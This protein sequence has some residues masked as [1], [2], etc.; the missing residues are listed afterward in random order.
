MVSSVSCFDI[1]YCS[2]L[3]MISQ[4]LKLLS[5]DFEQRYDPSKNSRYIWFVYKEKSLK[6]YPYLIEFLLDIRSQAAYIYCEDNRKDVAYKCRVISLINPLVAIA[7]SV[8]SL[9]KYFFYTIN[10][11]CLALNEKKD[12][13]QLNFFLAKQSG[14]DIFRSLFYGVLMEVAAIYGALGG[15]VYKA[16]SIY[17]RHERILNRQKRPS[18]S[19]KFYIA[20]C[21][22]PIASFRDNAS[23]ED[24]KLSVNGIIERLKYVYGKKIFFL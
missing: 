19:K 8:Y 11:V 16:R 13:C 7:R 3:D 1:P 14:A 12:L 23:R 24:G 2:D 5:N 21:F 22:Q 15:D 6:S 18:F 20:P 9:A 17:G 10:T 4:R